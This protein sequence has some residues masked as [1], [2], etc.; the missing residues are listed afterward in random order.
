[1]D[2]KVNCRFDDG[3]LELGLEPL[4]IESHVEERERIAT[5]ESPPAKLGGLDLDFYK[6]A[7]NKK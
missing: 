6:F 3:Q 7:T 1:M 5:G 2:V 4:C